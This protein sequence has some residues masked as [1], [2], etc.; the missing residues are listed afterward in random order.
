MAVYVHFRYEFLEVI[1]AR[2]RSFHEDDVSL[3]HVYDLLIQR[4]DHDLKIAVHGLFGEAEKQALSYVILP[5]KI[6]R[7]AG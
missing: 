3:T 1:A 5:V 2:F 4:I 6:R 7:P